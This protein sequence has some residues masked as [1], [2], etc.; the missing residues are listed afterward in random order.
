MSPLASRGVPEPATVLVVYADADT[1]LALTNLVEPLCAEGFRVLHGA[2]VL[3]EPPPLMVREALDRGGSVVI[4]GTPSSAGSEK[5]GIVLRSMRNRSAELRLLCVRMDLDARLEQLMPDGEVVAWENKEQGIADLLAALRQNEFSN[6]WPWDPRRYLRYQAGRLADDSRYCPDLYVA[7]RFVQLQL[8]GG[9]EAPAETP[10]LL[11][12]TL[13]WLEIDEAPLLLVLGD[14]GSGKSFLLRQ[15]ARQVQ[16]RFPHLVP[17]LVELR[18]LH[19]EKSNALKTLLVMHLVNAQENLIDINA[20]EQMVASGQVILLIDGFDELAQRVT[21]GE[22]EAL[23][24]PILSAVTE[25][26]K[27]VLTS[28]TQHFYSDSQWRTALSEQVHVVTGSRQVRIV[29]FDP[30][31]IRT[32]LVNLERLRGNSDRYADERLTLIKRIKDLHDL[33]RN[34][35]MLSF[36]ADLPAADLRAAQN[37]TGR[38]SSADLYGILVNR[39]LDFEVHRWLEI[40][41]DGRDSHGTP[42]RYREQLREALDKLAFTLWDTKEQDVGLKQL[43]QAAARALS[44]WEELHFNK[45]QA[46]HALG[47]GSLLVR[48]GDRFSFIHRSVMEY[49]VAAM[50]ARGI[51]GVVS[52]P[53]DHLSLS[54]LMVDFLCGSANSDTVAEWA[55]RVLGDSSAFPHPNTHVARNNAVRV[56]RRLGLVVHHAQLARQDLRGMDLS[57]LS[58]RSADLSYAKL[59]DANLHHT[60]LSFADL[61]HANLAGAKLRHTD[62]TRAILLDAD[63]Q[64]AQLLEGTKL[65]GVRVDESRWDGAVLAGVFIEDKVASILREAGAYVGETVPTSSSPTVPG[66]SGATAP[67]AFDWDFAISYATE[68][69]EVA[70][71][72]YNNLQRECRVFFA[73][74]VSPNLWGEDLDKV[75][76]NIYGVRSRFVLVL[77]TDHYIR[78]HWTQVEYNAVVT[79]NPGRIL[80]IKLG[81]IPTD[82]PR[83]I[84]HWGGSTSDLIGLVSALLGK[85]KT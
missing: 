52:G 38:I 63:L 14:F 29:D 80:L 61:S 75:L 76:P 77:S 26:A 18:K 7:Q 68:D 15:L 78:K 57:R 20:V 41:R 27:V 43:E 79:S 33:S 71:T 69:I 70:R 5:I 74:E 35:R 1:D 39:W 48:H 46:A 12:A 85:L 2:D 72:I 31:E 59:G 40:D 65:M 58:L 36:I 13:Q 30:D 55:R 56:T 44:G 24:D 64:G 37:R 16:T 8:D 49:L 3:R 25:K 17:M 42:Q 73:P 21:Y 45:E 84:A 53:W 54:D 60:D 28:R 4:C 66:Q 22:V 6:D 32:F 34:P 82:L 50:V 23:L 81:A 83:N 47:S 11:D 10:S 62:L 67:D 51:G 9:A 19:L